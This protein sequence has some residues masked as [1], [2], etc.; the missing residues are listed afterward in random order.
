[1]IPTSGPFTSEDIAAEWGLAKPYTSEQ[2]AAAVG[3]S[4]PWSTNDL[5]GR[6]SA[7]VVTLVGAEV[8][9]EAI[10]SSPSNV[11]V[12]SSQAGA[13]VTGG[14]VPRTLA[15]ERVS[16]AAFTVDQQGQAQTT[17]SGVYDSYGVRQGVYRLKVT[18]NAGVVAYSTSNLT[19]TLTVSDSLA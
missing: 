8:S 17:F 6:A 11:G 13:S 12:T 10:T 5:R 2:I 15:W 16:G 18:D 7:M 4:I 19:V 9:G 14:K 3:L 1:M